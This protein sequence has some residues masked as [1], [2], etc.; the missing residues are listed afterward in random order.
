MRRKNHEI[1][2]NVATLGW[3]FCAA[4]GICFSGAPDE[5]A[6]VDEE[7]GTNS[8]ALVGCTSANAVPLMGPNISNRLGANAC[9][10]VIPQFLPSWWQYSDGTLRVQIANFDNQDNAFPFDVQW[11][12][13]CGTEQG[14]ANYPI[15]WQQREL[16]HP[17]A[18]PACGIVMKLGGNLT[19]ERPD[20]LGRL[21]PNRRDFPKP[22][23]DCKRSR[24]TRSA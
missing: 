3:Q 13:T 23:A 12:N 24:R 15:P 5:S 6:G 9:V 18:S 19:E 16:G 1:L 4:G 2:E 11:E 21:S 17:S 20:L 22:W 10:T 7:L 8:E 14:T